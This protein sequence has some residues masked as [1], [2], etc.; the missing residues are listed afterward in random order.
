MDFVVDETV[1]WV[2]IHKNEVLTRLENMLTL[3]LIGFNVEIDF[4]DTPVGPL[5]CFTISIE[6]ESS[7]IDRPVLLCTKDNDDEKP[8]RWYLHKSLDIDSLPL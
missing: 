1:E 2:E 3:D 4:I 7:E 6:D 8:A 5:K